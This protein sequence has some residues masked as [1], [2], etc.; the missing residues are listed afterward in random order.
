M[1]T[2]GRTMADIKNEIEKA[3]GIETIIDHLLKTPGIKVNRE[4]FLTG[5]FAKITDEKQLI[6]ILETGPYAAGI[7]NLTL[8]TLQKQP[9]KKEH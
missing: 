9:F 4:K 6:E 7:K 2:E 3:S 8:I 1:I 5:K